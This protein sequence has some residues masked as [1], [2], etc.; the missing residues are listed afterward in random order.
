LCC[1]FGTLL[2]YVLLSDVLLSLAWHFFVYCIIM[3]LLCIAINH[4]PRILF[5]NHILLFVG[6]MS[7]PSV[8]L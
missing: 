8:S 7:I 5:G 4:L 1:V 2:S 6:I 3:S